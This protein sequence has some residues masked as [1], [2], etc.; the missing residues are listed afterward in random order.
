M[1][2]FSRNNTTW[3]R[4][5]SP[6]NYF[7]AC[8]FC[9]LNRSTEAWNSSFVPNSFFLIRTSTRLMMMVAMIVGINNWMPRI[10]LPGSALL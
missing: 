10:S 4:G 2:R 6:P 3:V 5:G 8:S 9:S 1:P 7:L